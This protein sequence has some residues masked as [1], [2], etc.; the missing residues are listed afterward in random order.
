MRFSVFFVF[1]A[2]VII[3]SKNSDGERFYPLAAV[4][5]SYVNLVRFVARCGRFEFALDTANIVQD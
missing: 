4:V 2:S 3:T 1:V 5:L